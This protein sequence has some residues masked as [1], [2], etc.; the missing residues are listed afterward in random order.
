M[1]FFLIFTY[2]LIK[3]EI[4]PG[5]SVLNRNRTEQWEVGVGSKPNRRV[6]AKPKPE[7]RWFESNRPTLENVINPFEGLKALCEWSVFV[8]ISAPLDRLELWFNAV[9]V[10]EILQRVTFV[11]IQSHF[12]LMQISRFFNPDDVDRA[13]LFF[14]ILLYDDHKIHA[15]QW[16]IGWTIHN[17]FCNAMGRLLK[18]L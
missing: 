18:F 15:C 10:T 9:Y 4:F 13:F 12:D 16:K 6:A 7:I 17:Q 5:F 14:I 8:I 11:Q 2:F 1:S 3:T